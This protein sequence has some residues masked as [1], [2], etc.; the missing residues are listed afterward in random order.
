MRPGKSL[1]NSRYF[2]WALLALPS[3]IMIRGYLTETL[4]YGELMHASGEVSAR[5]LIVTMAVTPLRLM[6]PN[7]RWPLWLL[8]HRRYFGVATFAYALL[9]TLFY[10][11]K[12]AEFSKILT[13]SLEFEYWTGWLAFLIFSGLAATSNKRSVSILKAAWKKLHRWIY[14]AALLTFLHWIFVAFNFLPGVIH[15]SVLAM[16]EAIRIWKPRQSVPS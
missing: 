11:Q 5:L 4:Y 16:L 3:V 6:L 15:A 8:E 13:E 10:L 14:A 2:I 1:L 9:H 7:A 12:S